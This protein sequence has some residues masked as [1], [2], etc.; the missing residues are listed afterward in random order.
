MKGLQP[1]W[2]LAGPLPRMT[3]R[4]PPL[5]RPPRKP[6]VGWGAWASSPG[7]S[8]TVTPSVSLG[9]AWCPEGTSPHTVPAAGPGGRSHFPRHPCHP[10]FPA[11]TLGR[12][13]TWSCGIPPKWGLALDL[14][15]F[16]VP[17]VRNALDTGRD[18]TLPSRACSWVGSVPVSVERFSEGFHHP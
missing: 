7:L 6:G 9:D 16:L 14:L 5:H 13:L 15:H 18:A 4:L 1:P 17:M 12:S 3:G 11:P 10:T 8:L 2:G